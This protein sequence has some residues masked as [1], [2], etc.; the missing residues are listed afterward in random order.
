MVGEDFFM[1]AGCFFHEGHLQNRH[2]VQRV[3]ERPAAQFAVFAEHL[4]QLLLRLRDANAGGRVGV[5]DREIGVDDSVLLAVLGAVPEDGR[6]GR[7]KRNAFARVVRVGFW[8]Q[9]DAK[10]QTWLQFCLGF[11]ELLLP[12]R[13]LYPI[14]NQTPN[15]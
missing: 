8:R 11:R 3:G 14:A 6:V 1:K 4:D 10:H 13:L 12:T 15:K 9:V 5:T 2:H 7:A